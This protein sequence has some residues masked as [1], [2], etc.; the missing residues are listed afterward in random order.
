MKTIYI[1]LSLLFFA[2][3]KHPYLYQISTR[4]WLY[5]LTKKY[6][7][8]ITKLK[9]I[10]L[11][12]FDILAENG[13][14]IVWM[15][16]VWQLGEYGLNFDRQEPNYSKYSYLLPDFI[17]DDVIGSPFAITEYSCNSEFGSDEDLIWLKREINI[18]GMK[19]MLDFVP[20]HSAADCDCVN[21]DPDMYIRAPEG[22]ADENRYNEKGFAYGSDL[23]HYPWKDVIQWNYFNKKTIEAMKNN[24]KKV[25]TL[26]DAVRCDVAYLELTDV[27]EETWKQE[28]DYYKYT[29][30]EK[31][32]W[33]Y[34]IEEARKI[35]PNAI[36][37]AESYNIEYN[38]QLI[39]LGFDY[40]YN[41][42]LLDNLIKSSTEVKEYLKSKDT[43]FWDKTCN[44]VENHDE[45]RIVFMVDGN[46][47]KAKAAG[48][49]AFTVG[50]M[51]FAFHGQWEG[52]KNQLEVH[53]RRS[54]DE[55]VN[56]EVQNHY[57]KLNQ[58]L[59]NQ[60][61]R[62]SNYYYI[63]SIYGEKKDDF[64]AYIR[65]EGDN[66]FLIVV[67]YSENKGCAYIPIYNIK[68]FKYCL[69]HESLNDVEYVRTVDEV[70]NGMRV[71][72]DAWESNIF[73][74][75]Y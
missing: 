43:S 30:P 64:V 42:P 49:I 66:H 17:I 57:N 67:N 29:R 50:G 45:K 7:K 18:R 61:F 33:T 65:E 56:F 9:D 40:V 20:N 52:K 59:S 16:G 51:M 44:F 2:S 35:N 69:L 19:L 37:V 6:Q 27:F 5:E 54:A 73:Q 8:P 48:T 15:L 28:L 36:I 11:Q 70:K 3:C 1:F 63:D 4:P 39:K 26:A 32:F 58:V 31:E 62:S 71:C 60:A 74:Y 72:L 23:G 12:E 55:D 10:P 21:T 38:N 24:F 53:L 46:Y 14:D 13:I 68:G 47:Q 22:K 25:L 75:N 41:K 34:A